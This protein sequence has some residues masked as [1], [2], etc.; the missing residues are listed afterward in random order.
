MD[1]ATL[2]GGYKDVGGFALPAIG[3]GTRLLLNEDCARVVEQAT[4]IGYRYIDTA[5]IYENEAAIGVGLRRS[6]V[7]RADV[8]VA[9]KVERDDLEASALRRSVERSLKALAFDTIDL[10]IIHWPNDKVPLSESLAAM[11]ALK[12]EGLI[13]NLG[14]A[15]FPIA[16]LDQALELAARDG[17]RIAVNQLEIHP[18][19]PQSKLIAACHARGVAPIAYSPMGREVL[20]HPVVRDMASRHDRT[21]AQIVLRWHVQRGVLP[22]P[23]PDSGARE[24]VAAQHAIFDFALGENEIALLSS[25]EPHRRFFNPPWAPA[26]DAQH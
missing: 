1:S 7:D 23:I 14:V 8:V 10:L 22:I 19:L 24:Q 13:K 20:A 12:R 21:P 15:N 2:S 17:E 18:S 25:I 6:G 26:W 5:P 9:T 11:C 16:L 4:A 3:L